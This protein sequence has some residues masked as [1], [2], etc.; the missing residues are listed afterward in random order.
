M[1][2]SYLLPLYRHDGPFATAYLD[3]TEY[4]AHGVHLVELR[5]RAL[6]RTLKARE[7]PLDVLD[8]M[9]D[10]IADRLNRSLFGDEP[11]T[12]VV[13][14]NRERVLFNERVARGAPLGHTSWDHLPDMF[15]L[16]ALQLP[17]APH[18]VVVKAMPKRRDQ[19]VEVP[20]GRAAGSERVVTELEID[21]AV[22][23]DGTRR[24]YGLLNTYARELGRGGQAV[25]G[26]APTVAA[27]AQRN[28]EHLFIAVGGFAQ[29][30]AIGGQPLDLAVLPT[31]L[32]KSLGRHRLARADA[33]LIRAAVGG[34]AEVHAV[35]EA[36]MTDAR[37]WHDGE[38]IGALLRHAA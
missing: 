36:G 11:G 34:G 1:N 24:E 13:V 28:V 15:P 7:V 26:L 2:V 3:T 17:S 5:W 37:P 20:D 14:A 31:D 18:I 16:I 22:A 38:Q 12:L 8:R 10:T 29:P 33:A 6:R 19:P 4:G 32:P 30:I 35:T 27:L 21:L 25:Q 23:D 9:S